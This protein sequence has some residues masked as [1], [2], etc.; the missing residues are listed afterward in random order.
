MKFIYLL[1]CF[2]LLTVTQVKSQNCAVVDKKDPFTNQHIIE[3]SE[4]KVAG[5]LLDD[6]GYFLS[7]Q[8]KDD[9]LYLCLNTSGNFM[10]TH[11]FNSV[12]IKFSDDSI[13]T[14]GDFTTTGSYRQ[15]D[16]S[17]QKS[18][19]PIDKSTLSKLANTK[20]I[21]LRFESARVNV[22]DGN[23]R[24]LINQSSKRAVGGSIID[25]TL[26]SGKADNVLNISKCISSYFLTPIQTPTTS[27]NLLPISKISS[28]VSHSRPPNPF[29]IFKKKPKVD[30]TLKNSDHAVAKPVQSV[31]DELKKLKELLDSGALTQS[32][33][34][35]Q[36]KKLL[37][38]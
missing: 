3:T 32:E 35:A 9:N 12:L 26:S 18:Y 19:S 15:G 13:I 14:L 29:S 37:S 7:Y 16:F 38:Q 8:L 10:V 36:K 22:T 21:N 28:P 33:F 2:I 5:A 1:Q 17:Y 34:D 25:A 30:D 31:A 20:I 23:G 11:S 6:K 27:G 24:S 4:V